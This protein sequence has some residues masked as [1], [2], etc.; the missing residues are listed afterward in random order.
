[1]IP[2][3]ARGLPVIVLGAGRG[4]RFGGPKLFAEHKGRGFLERI[5]TRCHEAGARVT[6]VTD[7]RDR[8]ALET[9]LT[10]LPP[11]LTAPFPRMVQADG[12][13]DMMASARAAL[14]QGP[15]E[16]GFWL[17]PVDAP[18]ISAGGWLRAVETA[19]R[20][21]NVVWK[22]RARGR[23]GHPI[24]FPFHTAPAILAGSW[25]D[26]LRGFLNT[27]APERIQALALEDEYL[28]DV[29]TPGQLAG[30]GWLE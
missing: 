12:E 20:D 29:N 4:T 8:E 1:V 9:L 22:L 2:A 28:D 15:Y 26:G 16:P 11:A 23:T 10:S 7:P 13:A 3:E 27:Q 19:A 17:W 6:L 18:F 24:W 25:P 14:A 5:L 21:P 30:L